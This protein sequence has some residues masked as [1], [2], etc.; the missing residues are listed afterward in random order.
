MGFDETLARIA[1]NRSSGN[2][3]RA[4]D[5]LLSGTAIEVCPPPFFRI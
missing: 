3:E 2:V 5:L 4:I 1:L